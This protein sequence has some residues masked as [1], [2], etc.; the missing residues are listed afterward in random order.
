MTSNQGEHIVLGDAWL[1]FARFPIGMGR[2]GHSH[3]SPRAKSGVTIIQKS[4]K[5]HELSAYGKKMNENNY[6]ADRADRVVPRRC[7]SDGK[8]IRR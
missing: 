2:G 8:S 4:G 3:S 1:P 5:N 6:K 7:D